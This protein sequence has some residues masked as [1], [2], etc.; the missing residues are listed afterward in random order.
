MTRVVTP[1]LLDRDAGS[2]AEIAAS[3][4]DLQHINSWFGGIGTT[5]HAIQRIAEAT[6]KTRFALLDVASASGDVPQKTRERLHRGRFDRH[7][8]ADPAGSPGDFC[9]GEQ[10]LLVVVLQWDEERIQ[11]KRRC[12]T[13]LEPGQYTVIGRFE[14][15]WL[16]CRSVDPILSRSL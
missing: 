2:P 6:G 1:E 4:K 11:P 7:E 13:R 3:L 14:Q 5:C 9:F 15:P 8:C 16:L 12:P 10:R